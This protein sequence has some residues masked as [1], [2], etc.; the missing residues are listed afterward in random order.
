MELVVEPNHRNVFRVSGLHVVGAWLLTRIATTV[1]R[2]FEMSGRALRALL[3]VPE[4]RFI[5]AGKNTDR[6]MPAI[7]SCRLPTSAGSA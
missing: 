5:C 1:L 2:L 7:A 6:P 3:V 4:L